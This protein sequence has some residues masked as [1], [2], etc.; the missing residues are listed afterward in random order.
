M[1]EARGYEDGKG[2]RSHDRLD[3]FHSV[4]FGGNFEKHK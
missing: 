1:T 4:D 3:P 2:C